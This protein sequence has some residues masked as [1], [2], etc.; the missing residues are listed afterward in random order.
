MAADPEEWRPISGWEGL[1]E[2]SNLGR[3]KSLPRAFPMHGGIKRTRELIRKLRLTHDGY[4][5]LILSRGGRIGPG[6]PG[7]YVMKRV[8]QLVCEA[9]HGPRP[10]V[11]HQVAHGDG[12]RTNNV[13]T[14]LR[15]AT[16]AENYSDRHRHGT[17]LAGERNGNAKLSDA[18]AAEIRRRSAWLN[19]EKLAKQY[20]VSSWTIGR[21][22]RG[23]RYREVA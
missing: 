13:A 20:G 6:A 1:Y 15:W 8:H 12:V 9:F 3:V 22:V 18:Q 5:C 11:G 7:F 14:N 4:P 21:I 19:N 16:P 23:E 17:N 10:S 2:V